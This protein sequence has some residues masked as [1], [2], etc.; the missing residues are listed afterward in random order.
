MKETIKSENEINSVSNE[1]ERIN[2]AKELGVTTQ[3]VLVNKLKS[4]EWKRF[5]DWHNLGEHIF[6]EYA[7]FGCPKITWDFFGRRKLGKME[8]D[9]Y[10]FEQ[11]IHPIKTYPQRIPMSALIQA[12]EASESGMKDFYIIDPNLTK[13]CDPFL[14]GIF[15]DE[16]DEPVYLLWQWDNKDE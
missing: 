16:A 11:H 3:T 14:V 9:W 7:L 6:Q 15:K 4:R 10:R 5:Y 1:Q 2:L 12:K 13:N 8:F